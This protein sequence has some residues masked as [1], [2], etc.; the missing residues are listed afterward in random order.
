MTRHII[1]VIFMIGILSL[2]VV[3]SKAQKSDTMYRIAKIKVDSSQLEKYK[4]ALLEQMNAAIELEQGVL[5]Y[6]AVSDKKDPTLIT[7]FEVYASQEAY[8]S[9]ILAPHFKKYKET[10]KDMVL[11][12]ELIDSDLIARAKK[13][14]Y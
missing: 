3:D 12:L 6:T 11:S 9:H 7:I 1:S 13:K 14:D 5:S 4:S 10:V 2:I 8:Q